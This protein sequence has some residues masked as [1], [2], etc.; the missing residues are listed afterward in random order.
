MNHAD[1]LRLVCESL[2]NGD[3]E[4][5]ASTL[6]LEYPFAAPQAVA[7][8]YSNLEALRV[9]SRDGFIDRYS[10]DRLVFPGALRVI[11]LLL[12]AEFPF[13]PNWKMSETHPA[14]WELSPTVDHVVPIARGGAD[15]ESNWV[16]TSMLRNGAKAN[17]TL[18]E[19]GWTLRPPG[20]P[21]R[22]DGL[23]GWFHACLIEYPHLVANSHVRR[24]RRA[25]VAV[26][27][28]SDSQR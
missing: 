26:A 11:S 28:T 3:I 5:A 13:H 23:M 16:T 9:F 17:W 1:A 4:T 19:L 24:W 15:D 7:R 22:W 14:F 8:G 20:D 21:A 12:P 10:G 27:G 2:L 18:E 25:A 6:K